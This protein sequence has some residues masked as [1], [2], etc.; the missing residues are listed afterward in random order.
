MKNDQLWKAALGQLE[1]RVSQGNFLTWFR[2][3]RIKDRLE[4]KV[5]VETSTSFT[6][7]W[8]SKR[9]RRDILEV[10]QSLDESIAAVD[11][12]VASQAVLKKSLPRSMRVVAQ[13]HKAPAPTLTTVSLTE[14]QP[15]QILPK[16]QSLGSSSQQSTTLN[17]KYTFESYIV[18]PSNEIAHAACQ[19]VASKPGE[20][21]NPLFIYG[22]VGLGKTHLL[23]AV[24]NTILA[25]NPGFSILYVSAEKFANDFVSAL[26]EKKIQHFK[27]YYRS[28]DVFIIDDV[29]FLAGKDKTQEEL[30][31]TFNTL[32]G[33]N[34][35]VILSSDR[36]PAAIATLQERLASRLAAGIIADIKKPDYETRLAIL[37]HKTSQRSL[38]IDQAALEFIAKNIQNN[39]RELEGALNRVAA[40][41]QLHNQRAT[42]EYTKKILS[43]LLEHSVRRS[44]GTKQI[45]EAVSNYY[46]MSIED[47]C[48]K[49]RKK[50]IV[51]PRQVAMYLLRKENSM[52]FPSIGEYFGGRDHTTAM[53]ACDKIERLLEH[54][55][56]LV[57]EINF[58]K[59]RLYV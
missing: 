52:S 53:H 42:L 45:I 57:Q 48:G 3:T 33:Q 25:A 8:L 22:G 37:E 4:D 41:S 58:L 9:Y 15:S 55:E 54:D 36:P 23:Q 44:I 49:C 32:H 24:G 19:A 26:R 30:F 59:E 13:K 46:N 18:G 14:S 43:D 27:K 1:L 20:A 12:T 51:K 11:F 47:I 17:P 2:G 35:Q 7:E 50:E 31:H 34:K 10:L 5:V 21:Y 38:P 6:Y 39:V 28:I 40:H 56:E 29:Q 16:K